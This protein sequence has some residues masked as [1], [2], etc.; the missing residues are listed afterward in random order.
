LPN[1]YDQGFSIRKATYK[2]Y[3]QAIPGAFAI[4]KADKAPCR[5]ACPAGLNVQ[6][7]VQMVGQGKYKE[8]LQIIMEDLPLPGVLGRICPHGCED[9]CRR[10]DVDSPV[11]IRNL[12]RLAADQFDPRDIPVACLPARNEKVA[13]IGSGPAGL[14][15][16][17]HLARKGILSTIYEALPVAGGM[18]RV[19]IPEH[20]L[21]RD[22]LDQEIEVITRLGVDIKTNTPLGPDLTVDDLFG[23]G[24][25]AVYLAIGAHRGIELGVPGEKANGV[26]QGVDFLREVNLTGKADVGEHVAIIGGGNVAI[27]V[28]RCAVRLG[29]KHVSIIYRRTR[30]E[31]PAWEEEIS[32]AETEGVTIEY[33][34]AP[35]EILTQDGKVV[36]LRCIR[37]QLSDVDSSGRRRPIPVPGT[38]YDIDIDQLIPAIGQRPDLSAIEDIGGLE[39]SRWGTTEVDAISYAT[40]REGVFAG[41]DVQT[42]PWVAIGAIAAGKEAA[43][44][45]LRYIDGRDMVKG[46][47]P[48]VREN[49]V[50]RP[51]P[52]GI[53][54]EAR[55]EMPE[56][57][58]KER[59]GNFKEVELGYEATAGQ[60]EAHR[61]LNCG[62]CCECYQCVEACGPKAVTLDTHAQKPETLE[63]EVGSVILAPGFKP[64][65]PSKFE[66]YNY[67]KHP[68]VV[69]SI[70]FER[71]LS[72]TGPTEGHL[73]RMSDHKEPKKIAWF[74]CVGS[75][76]MNRCD[77]AYC[78]SVCCMY[79]VKEAVIAKEHAG[80]HLDC[81]VFFMDMRTHGKDF[82]KYYE[83]AEKKH[84]V[85]FVRSRVHTVDPVPGTDDLEVRYVTDEGEI[86]TEIFDQIVL[87]VGMEI[88]SEIVDLAKRLGIELSEGNFCKTDSVDP[89]ASPRKGIYVCGAFQGPKDIP[90]SVMEASSAACSA[91]ISLA[92]ARGSLVREKTFP[93]ESEVAGKEARI[94]VFVCNCGINIGGVADV[95]AIA[96]YAKSLPNVAYVEENLFTCS[97]DTQDKMVEVIK[98]QNLNRIVVA[99][100]TPRTHEP[101][102]QETIRNAGLNAYL[103]DMANIRNQCTWVHANDKK[104]ATEKSK[105]LVRMAVNR[106]SLLEPIPDISVGI[107]KSA[108]VIGGGVAGMT[109]AL[110]LAD[111]GFPATIVEKSPELGGAAKDLKKTWKGQDVQTYLSGLVDKVMQHPDIE[112]LT[113]AEVTGASGFVGNFETRVANG[114][115]TKTVQHGVTIVATGGKAAAV[116]EYLYG[117]NP[118]VTRWHDLEHDPE[119]LKEAGCVVFIQCVGSRDDNRP[120]CSRICCTASVLQAISIK[121]QNPDT[122]VFILY[123]DIRTY[124]EKEYLYKKAREM[125][126]IFV[127][128]SLENKPKVSEI[129]SGLQVDVFD[130]I[131]QKNIAIKADYVNLATAVEPADNTAISEFYKVPLNAENF[132]MEAHAK[133]RPV[134]FATD[135]IFL[136]GLAHYPKG[137][138]E[139]IAQ[140]MAAASRATTILA[141]KSVQISPLVSQVDADKC[142]GC[143]LCTEVCSFAAINLEEVEGKGYRARNIS[144]S[145]KGCGLCAA[146]CPQHAIDML[147]FRDAQ[148][149]ASVCAAI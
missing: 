19:G 61:C 29:A 58:L 79:A 120:Y 106:A 25:K 121:E 97:Q 124:G 122:D 55:A 89:I 108:L 90:E 115:G 95:P 32:A 38:E 92:A 133:L 141:K 6:A 67:I 85:R 45:I 27:D 125:G 114:N 132:F 87:S 99:A 123:R 66:N 96:E 128:Y 2:K 14:S 46:R 24:Y 35:Q 15:A 71:I 109:A 146:S 137:I 11:A 111:Q 134:D 75:R 3:A 107:N 142:I 83:A 69:T 88:S 84:G 64:F 20:R 130:P 13:I 140:A 26:R 43:E 42:G 102:F 72:A 77:N 65:D 51:I 12:K 63:L 127:R 68:N 73:V 57:A 48:V 149:I 70:E 81:A 21:P 104:S 60:A 53:A 31:M 93:A 41:G 86:K 80:N 54:E 23:K 74:Q 39:I 101:L 28:A 82:E 7:Y 37:M 100:C 116:D 139:S 59:K 144:A 103:F 18:L 145:C 147:H 9:A 143:G 30:A 22:I 113:G 118:R 148:I 91:G 117:K 4:Q 76:D 131:L 98:E 129:E 44:S 126:V 52:R 50:Y 136:C 110:S 40:G 49:P 34:S 17:Y 1:E 33:L 135:G 112:V 8:A 56:L 119:K 10:C 5:L 94:G 36:G 47:E 78:S 62:Y 16:A 105:D 138:D